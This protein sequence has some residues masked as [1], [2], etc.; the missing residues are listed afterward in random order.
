M[1]KRVGD[2]VVFPRKP[3]SWSDFF[4]APSGVPRTFLKRRRDSLPQK[5]RGLRVENW[6]R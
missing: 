1:V 2:T 6:A 3:D 5:R 4:A